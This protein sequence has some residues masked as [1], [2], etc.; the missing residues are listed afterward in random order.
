MQRV[1][2]SEMRYRRLFESAHDGILI[3]DAGS[4]E[5]LDV[6]PYLTSLLGYEA[7]ELLGKQPWEI[8]IFADIDANKAALIEL[9]STGAI[10]YENLP[11]QTK[12]HQ[13]QIDVEFVSNTYQEGEQAVIQCNI[14]D[15]RTRKTATDAANVEVQRGNRMKDEFIAMIAHELRTPLNAVQGWSQVLRRSLDNPVRLA[16]GLNAILGS[17]RVQSRLVEDLLDVSR[18]LLGKLFCDCQP[19]DVVNV[20]SDAIESARPAADGKRI[21]LQ[22]ADGS[23]EVVVKGDAVRLHQVFDN[24]LTNAIKFTPVGGT[25]NVSLHLSETDVEIRISDTGSGILPDLLPHV[26][27]R[28]R[29]SEVAAHK[30][31]GLGLGLAIVKE[32]VT[33]HGGKVKAESEGKGRGAAFRVTLPLA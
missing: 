25:V 15:I 22:W 27:D 11:L 31:G 17:A 9:Q 13:H 8:G 18:I 19:L 10:R 33:L 1:A 2:A 21:D 12:D 16:T 6:N 20:V 29:Q 28:Y 23:R 26:F 7:E 32:L 5:I 4:G 14:R 3:L 30:H 24:I